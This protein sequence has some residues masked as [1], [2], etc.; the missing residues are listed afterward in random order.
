MAEWQNGRHS[1]TKT[2]REIDLDTFICICS[3]SRTMATAGLALAVSENKLLTIAY[4]DFY[5]M[6]CSRPENVG[7]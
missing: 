7:F 6:Q 3:S 2:S 4:I 1:T 5:C